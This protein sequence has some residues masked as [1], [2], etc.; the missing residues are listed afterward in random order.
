MAKYKFVFSTGDI[1]NYI[2]ANN[3]EALKAAKGYIDIMKK[4]D[5]RVGYVRV[6][7]YIDSNRYSMIGK[8]DL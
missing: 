1:C 4:I 7:K 2:G 5:F 3:S 6:Y 8:H